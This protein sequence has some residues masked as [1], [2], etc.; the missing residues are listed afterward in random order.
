MLKHHRLV[1]HLCSLII[2][3]PP[4]VAIAAEEGDVVT[5][6][7][8]AGVI[9]DNNLFR[10]PANEE[11]DTIRRLT[12]GVNVDLPV[13]LQRFVLGVGVNDNRYRRFDQL[14]YVGGKAEGAWNWQISDR[15][16]GMLGYR[17]QRV[18][19]DFGDL[20]TQTRD[21]ISQ[22]EPFFNVNYLL[23]PEW[24]LTGDVSRV[25]SNH[26]AVQRRALNY[27]LDSGALGV[28]YLT[29]SNNSVGLLVRRTSAD[30]PI[31]QTIALPGAFQDIDNSFE[32]TETSGV[33]TWAFGGASSVKARAGY[34][35]RKHN[36]LAGRD[37]SGAT[38]DVNYHWIPSGNTYLDFAVYRQVRSSD[39]LSAS[40]VVFRGISFA[41]AWTPLPTITLKLRALRE[42]RDYNGDP[43]LALGTTQRRGDTL[44]NVQ[45]SAAYAP[46]KI[47]ELSV[48]FENGRRTSNVAAFEYN[49]NLVSAALN[50]SF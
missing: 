35:S 2:A 4:C 49:Y 5:F 11:S 50:A 10:T 20:Q 25:D 26:G 31:R 32:E 6:S 9:R 48:A 15:A 21:L 39:D 1:L 18:I 19:A 17:Y 3:L 30:Y 29:G 40:Y 22:R 34:T 37:F 42:L 14:D 46:T 8:G 41:P 36:D 45:F 23:T 27:K 38:G 13:S 44:R 28:N 7:A 33:V 24:Q 12:A 43:G 16:K 47:I